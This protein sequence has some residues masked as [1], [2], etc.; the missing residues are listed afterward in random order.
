MP[1]EPGTLSLHAVYNKDNPAHVTVF[2]IYTS[3]EA[4]LA[5]QQ[6]PHFFQYKNVTNDMVKSTERFEMLAHC[7][8]SK[9]IVISIKNQ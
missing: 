4:H 8:G 6:T 7:I 5:H 1:G 2:E 9:T 3:K